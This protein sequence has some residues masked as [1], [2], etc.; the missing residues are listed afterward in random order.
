MT[1]LHCEPV[2][3]LRTVTI[4]KPS[5]HERARAY[6]LRV[7]ELQQLLFI[8]THLYSTLNFFLSLLQGCYDIWANIVNEKIVCQH[9]TINVADFRIGDRL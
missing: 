7:L 1:C 9:V 3:Y 6:T 4:P 8:F 5:Y 2:T